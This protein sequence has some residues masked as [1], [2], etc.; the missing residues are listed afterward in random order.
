MRLSLSSILGLVEGS[1]AAAPVLGVVISTVFLVLF[2][3][4]QPYADRS[5]NSL[6]ILLAMSLV[7]FFLAALMIKV[8]ATSDD[9]DDQKVFGALLVGILCAG[10]VMSF[11][12]V[13]W[14]WLVV[15][16]V[17]PS[18]EEENRE[19]VPAAARD[20]RAGNENG[21]GGDDDTETAARRRP[22][23]RSVSLDEEEDDKPLGSSL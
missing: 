8:D 4:H 6:S 23:Q 20:D 21:Q 2:A 22:P 1:A 17:T 11:V 3:K 16:S 12:E 13:F 7:F 10:P 9:E 19:Q 14:G 5:D 15:P 18:R